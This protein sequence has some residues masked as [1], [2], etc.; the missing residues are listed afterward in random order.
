MAEYIHHVPGR[1]RVK[2]R[3]LKRNER[4]AAIAREHLDAVPG[5]TGSQINM[6]TG[7]VV[8]RYDTGITDSRV[9]LEGLAARLDLRAIPPVEPRGGHRAGTTIAAGVGRKLLDKVIET[10]VERSAMAL[11]GALI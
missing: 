10:A 3:V 4:A 9:I 1:L 11:I 2:S 5:V 7:S 8:V 6:I